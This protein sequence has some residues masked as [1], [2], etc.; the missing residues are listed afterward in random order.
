MFYTEACGNAG[1]LTH[2]LRPGI[3][4]T[5]SWR[6]CQVLNPL[7]HGGNSSP[8]FGTGLSLIT[9]EVGVSVGEGGGL[10]RHLIVRRQRCRQRF[11]HAQDVPQLVSSPKCQQC[12]CSKTPRGHP[13]IYGLDTDPPI[14]KPLEAVHMDGTELVQFWFRK[15]IHWSKKMKHQSWQEFRNHLNQP[16][17]LTVE[18]TWSL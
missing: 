12:W 13:E 8:H 18:E 7:S 10:L 15:K 3:E 9:S 6:P 17:Y 5:S 11:C 4:P 14:F 16:S 1:P 2:W